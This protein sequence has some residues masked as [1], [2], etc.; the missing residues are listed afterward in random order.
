MKLAEEQGVVDEGPVWNLTFGCQICRAEEEKARKEEDR[1]RYIEGKIAHLKRVSGLGAKWSKATFDGFL[2]DVKQLHKGNKLQYAEANTLTMRRVKKATMEWAKNFEDK[3][4]TGEMLVL[5]GDV[6]T[7][8]NHL[9]SAIINYVIENFRRTCLFTSITQ[10]F[11]EIKASFSNKSI[12]E[13]QVVEKFTKIEL[14]VINE[15]GL[16]PGTDFEFER[17]SYILNERIDQCLPSI[18]VSNLTGEQL[19]QSVGDRMADRISGNPLLQF[20]W[21][22]FRPDG[23]R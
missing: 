18:L 7:G 13:L 21:P 10:M 11:M 2:T 15:V 16:H 22:S 23:S 5:S 20:K 3:M 9:S 12:D 1:R 19:E 8:K 6:G 17:I 4:K 14:L